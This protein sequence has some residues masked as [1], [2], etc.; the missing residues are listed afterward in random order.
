[1]LRFMAKE[2]LFHPR[3]LGRLIASVGAFPVRRGE[4]DTEAIRLAI[5][6]L[7]NG[8]AVLVFPEGTRGDGETLGSVNLGVSVFAKRSGAQVVPVALIGT[9]RKWPRGSKVPKWG[10]V[11]VAFGEPFTYAQTAV[12]DNERENREAFTAEWKRQIVEMSG[13]HGATLKSAS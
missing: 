11:V 3:A 5:S 6:H 8:E 1:M 4:G 13:R 9:A 7:Q 2:E 10:R 12:H